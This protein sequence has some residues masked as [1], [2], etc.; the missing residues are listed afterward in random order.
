MKYNIE[1]RKLL[2]VGKR[3]GCTKDFIIGLYNGLINQSN[4][5]L[6]E[7]LLW[8]NQIQRYFPLADWWDDPNKKNRI[9]VATFY[10][11][12]ILHYFTPSQNLLRRFF[13]LSVLKVKTEKSMT[14]RDR[15]LI[16]RKMISYYPPSGAPNK[17]H[18]WDK[19]MLISLEKE[20]WTL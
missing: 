18:F 4:F 13:F 20:I 2:I 12:L 1:I 5:F 7:D 16:E 14:S 6:Q 17:N 8:N 10:Q 19:K 9:K 3:L 11:F 15:E